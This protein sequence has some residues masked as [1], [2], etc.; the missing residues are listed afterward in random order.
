MKL[1]KSAPY[2]TSAGPKLAMRARGSLLHTDIK[3]SSISVTGQDSPAAERAKQMEEEEFQEADVLWP[4]P[5]DTPSPSPSPGEDYFPFPATELY[6]RDDAVVVGFSCEPFSEPSLGSSASTSS[7]LPFDPSSSGSSEDGFFLS[8]R[9][10]AVSGLAASLEESFLEKDVLWP[11]DDAA[12]FIWCRRC[13]PCVEEAAASA[14]GKREG[15][16]RLWAASS[17][18]DIPVAAGAAAARRR[19]SPSAVPR[20]RRW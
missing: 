7:A 4:W 17:P 11:D 2:V 13:R 8:G 19:P 18:I 16:R 20:H 12:E 6:E 14:C 1:T 10:T 3:C 9:S 15:W 5:E